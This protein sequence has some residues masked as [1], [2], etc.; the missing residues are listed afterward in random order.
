[1]GDRG[2]V[3]LFAPI[4]RV[5]RATGMSV[6][7]EGNELLS[8]L[9]TCEIGMSWQQRSEACRALLLLIESQRVRDVDK[10]PRKIYT[11]ILDSLR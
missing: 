9:Q 11:F 1:I 8:L 10:L 7:D 2:V 3:L 4:E 5:R 6:E